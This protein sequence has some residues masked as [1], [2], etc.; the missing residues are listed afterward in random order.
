ML[1]SKTF[2]CY[3]GA[4]A[5]IFG[6]RIS[7]GAPTQKGVRQTIIWQNIYQK[8]RENERILTDGSPLDPPLEGTGDPLKS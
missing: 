2:V 4:T 1:F 6:S 5:G 3:L 8:L 7:Q